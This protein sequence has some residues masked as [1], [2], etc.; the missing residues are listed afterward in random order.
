VLT[1]LVWGFSKKN[2]SAEKKRFF[3][4][5]PQTRGVCALAGSMILQKSISQFKL[6]CRASLVVSCWLAVS[7]STPK[8]A[9]KPPRCLEFYKHEK[10]LS[11]PNNL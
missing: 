6:L 10:H 8:H 1:P 4:E 7:L 2:K 11:S 3:F 5:N 9:P